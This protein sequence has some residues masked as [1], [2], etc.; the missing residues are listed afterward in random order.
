VKK[1]FGL[2]CAALLFVALK[3][4][5]AARFAVVR[6][7]ALPFKIARMYAG[8]PDRQLFMPVEGARVSRVGD[9][10]HVARS[11]GRLH[12]G[13]DIFARRGTAVRSATEGYVVQAGQNAL[14]G[15]WCG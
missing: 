3:D 9:S 11:G 15:T 2:A 4:L 1:F 14:A 12:E 5:D 8:E 10:W 7:A 13:Q 6:R